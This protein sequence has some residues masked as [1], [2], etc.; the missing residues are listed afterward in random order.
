MPYRG[1]QL[2]APPLD[3][4]SRGVGVSPSL[5]R[6]G[7]SAASTHSASGASVESI[8]QPGLVG[9]GIAPQEVRYV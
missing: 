1:K 8:E 9:E 5:A 4:N 7:L 3:P 2:N 6:R